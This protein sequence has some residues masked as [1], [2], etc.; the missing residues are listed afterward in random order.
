MAKGYTQET[1]EQRVKEVHGDKIDVSNFKYV[2]SITTGEAK[3]NICGNVWYP[4]A[5]VLIR[6]CGCRKCYDKKNSDSRIIPLEEIQSK[7]TCATINKYSYIDTKHHCEAKCNECGHIWY[8]NVRDLIN[9]SGCPECGKRKTRQA[10][11]KVYARRRKPKPPKLSKEENKEKNRQKYLKSFLERAH[12]KHKDKF[13]YDEDTF[14]TT[15]KKMRIICP[16]HGEFW[17]SP[18][19]H[20]VTEGCSK[21]GVELNAKNRT[22]PF[23]E[24]EKRFKEADIKWDYDKDSY[25][26]FTKPMKFFCKEHGE[27]SK[28][29]LS[30]L[31][32]GTCPL[33]NK[34]RPLTNEEF[35]EKA[36]KIHNFKY[37]YK[38]VNYVNNRTDVEIICSKHG[39]FW[40]TPNDHLDG[41]GCPKCY[42]S[43]LENDIQKVL[44]ENAIEYIERKSHPWLLNE[45]TNHKLTLDFFLPKQNIAIECQGEQHFISIEYFG[46]DEKFEKR[47]KYDNL[48]KELCQQNGV[49]LIYYFDKEF[50]KYMKDGDIYFN[51]IDDLINYIK[52]YEGT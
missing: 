31:D 22:M 2:N 24:V 10:L 14:S 41:C 28:S 34:T 4:R 5:D 3:C 36:N 20:L 51:N 26:T 17:Q 35:A 32:G 50:N 13:I 48:K 40:Q 37:I 7:I 18:K 52:G 11:E 46:G 29:P 9:G 25:V 21:C 1:F 44:K 38:N 33:C 8:P 43:K 27:F 42:S 47:I 12:E 39:S 45:D 19:Q 15:K 30:I 16:T 49:K 6:G 23:E